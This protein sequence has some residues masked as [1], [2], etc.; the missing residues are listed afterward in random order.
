[1][2][3]ATHA[4]K[5]QDIEGAAIEAGAQNVEPLE[6]AAVPAGQVGARFFCDPTDLDACSKFLIKNGWSVTMSELSYQAK[7][8]VEVSDEERKSVV[9]FLEKLDD[10]DDVHRIYAALK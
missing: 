3:E 4:D 5:S 8:F 2:V 7:N 10:N 9:A 6:G 1:V